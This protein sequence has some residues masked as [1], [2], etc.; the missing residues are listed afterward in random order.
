M[1]QLPKQLESKWREIHHEKSEEQ[2][3]NVLV[4]GQDVAYSPSFFDKSS[5]QES[6]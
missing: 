4:K 3:T 5:L 2:F 1:K 6:V